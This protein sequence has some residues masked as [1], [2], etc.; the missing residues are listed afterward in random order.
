DPRAVGEVRRMD[1]RC[2]R[3]LLGPGREATRHHPRHQDD[4]PIAVEIMLTNLC[5]A[6][7][8]RPPLQSTEDTMMMSIPMRTQQLDARLHEQ[9]LDVAHLRGALDVQ[10]NRISQM[11]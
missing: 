4:L 9:I 10:M 3:P 6:A 5:S 8:F 7:A 11:Y 2:G 1:A